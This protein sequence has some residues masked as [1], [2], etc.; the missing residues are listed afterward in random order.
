MIR[1][2]AL[3]VVVVVMY[4]LV[5]FIIRV[6]TEHINGFKVISS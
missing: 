4:V 2:I 6:D 5:F 3:V 1:I